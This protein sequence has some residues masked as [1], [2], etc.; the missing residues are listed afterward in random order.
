MTIFNPEQLRE[1]YYGSR[2]VPTPYG[3]YKPTSR[4][5]QTAP[6]S[7]SRPPSGTQHSPVPPR[8]FG[9]PPNRLADEP[10]TTSPGRPPPIANPSLLT[11]VL[12]QINRP[13]PRP[14]NPTTTNPS[15]IAP[16]LAQIQRDREQANSPSP[17]LGGGGTPPGTGSGSP[18]FTPSRPSHRPFNPSAFYGSGRPTS[19][20]PY[21]GGGGTPPGTGQ[22]T[23][24][25]IPSRPAFRPTSSGGGSPPIAPPDVLQDRYPNPYLGGGGYTSWYWSTWWWRKS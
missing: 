18:N 3:T 12:S 15:L 2:P 17:Y 24:N 5:G 1:Q 4:P 9:V 11:P 25:N 22:S 8:P 6:P 13:S 20:T 19:T 14:T 10:Q 21:L 23:P 16:V 7:T